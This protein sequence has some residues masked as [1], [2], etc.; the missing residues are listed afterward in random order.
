MVGTDSHDI[1]DAT[2]H[3]SRDVTALTKHVAVSDWNADVCI[4]SPSELEDL[5][6]PYYIHLVRFG[7]RAISVM[8][9]ESR[10]GLR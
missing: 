10:R 9:P 2:H 6:L 3:Q 1:A 7:D 4:A 5:S 8:R